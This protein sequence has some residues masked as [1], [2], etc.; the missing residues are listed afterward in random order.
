MRISEKTQAVQ[1]FNFFRGSTYHRE[2]RTGCLG[3]RLIV[4]VVVKVLVAQGTHDGVKRY[5]LG[6]VP[7]SRRVIFPRVIDNTRSTF[8]ATARHNEATMNVSPD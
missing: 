7:S 1:T 3:V 5:R 2:N 8:G 6:F 4:F